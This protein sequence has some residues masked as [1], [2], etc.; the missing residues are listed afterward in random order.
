VPAPEPPKVEKIEKVEKVAKAEKV[1]TAAR[2]ESAP[3]PPA[4]PSSELMMAQASPRPDPRM[5]QKQEEAPQKSEPDYGIF[6]A[7]P[8]R[9]GSHRLAL[10]AR[11]PKWGYAYW[12]V[13]RSRGYALFE[14]GAQAVLRLLDAND[15]RVLQ[16]P[17]VSAFRCRI[18][19]TS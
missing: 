16:S 5:E 15:G 9:Y 12:D 19:A 18:S 3:T 4:A 17:R 11:D 7:L 1:E 10:I 2:K 14:S 8:Q 6:A 13:E